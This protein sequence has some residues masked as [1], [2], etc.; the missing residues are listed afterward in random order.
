MRLVLRISIE[1][2]GGG[3]RGGRAKGD[4]TGRGRGE[5]GTGGE[6]GGY[7]LRHLGAYAT[8]RLEHQAL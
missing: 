6:G 2:G 1:Y 5:K 4:K 8:W 7:E 3:G